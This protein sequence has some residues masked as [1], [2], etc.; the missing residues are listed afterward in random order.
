[1]AKSLSSSTFF[2]SLEDTS[3]LET[4]LRHN[5]TS[6][7]QDIGLISAQAAVLRQRV[8]HERFIMLQLTHQLH[9]QSKHER[10]LRIV[11]GTILL[12]L[13]ASESYEAMHLLTLVGRGI[14]KLTQWETSIF[15]AAVFAQSGTL[16]GYVIKYLFSDRPDQSIKTMIEGMF[17]HK[18]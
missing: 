17:H 12:F 9:E 16:L 6:E 7:P 8:S 2:S 1:M 18:D 10:W 3:K 11:F 13:F 4:L 15:F 5:E 14:L